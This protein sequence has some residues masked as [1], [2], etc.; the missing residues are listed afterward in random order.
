MNLTT[1]TVALIGVTEETGE[2]SQESVLYQNLCLRIL[3]LIFKNNLLSKMEF[4]ESSGVKVPNSVIVSEIT[5][6]DKE[7]EILTF[8]KGYGS[9]NRTFTVDD[10]TSELHSNLIVEYTY[11]TA[12]QTLAQ[13][14][15][16]DSDTR[17]CGR[18]LA[19]V[20]CRQ[21]G[22]SVTQTCL[23]ELKRVAK[24]SGKDFEEKF[25][26]ALAQI[27]ESVEASEPAEQQRVQPHC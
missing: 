1:R 21:V 12:L 17:Y 15:S 7:E 6:S 10:P 25:K 19:E 22:G 5:G 3:G 27:G 20:Y 14:L 18:A 9:I 11:G 2:P 4:I 13:T 8:L 26:E 23:G 16:G 24:L